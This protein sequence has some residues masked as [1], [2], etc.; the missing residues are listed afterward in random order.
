LVKVVY[1]GEKMSSTA[2]FVLDNPSAFND[3]CADLKDWVTKSA[4][5]TVNIQ[6]A[7]ARR[8]LVARERQDFILRNSFTER[9]TQ[10]T[11]MPKGNVKS[12]EDVRATVGITE[13]AAY[14]AR[15]DEGGYH[16]PESGSRLAIATDKARTGKDKKKTVARRYRMNNIDALKITGKSKHSA[17][18]ARGVARAYIAWKTKKL[19]HYGKDLFAVT[20][21]IKKSDGVTFKI[22]KI[23]EMDYTQTYTSGKEYF[24]P[25]C[26]KVTGDIQAIF[27]S[28]M[29]KNM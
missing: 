23:Y 13:K 6:A 12:L 4:I 21:F 22:E 7:L 15:Q 27:N 5:D 20:D 1:I 16:T 14:M 17:T 9:Q 29:N 24:L 26:E 11:Q 2:R 19:V 28:Q 10:I 3:L 25:E 18:K 8:N